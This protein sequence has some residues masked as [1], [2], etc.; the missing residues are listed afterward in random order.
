MQVGCDHCYACAPEQAWE[1]RQEHRVLARLVDESHFS[2][3]VLACAHCDQRFVSVFAEEIDWANG[4]DPQR[5]LMVPITAEE[6]ASLVAAGKTVG[7][8]AI[9]QL[10][11][12]RRYLDAEFPKG[13]PRRIGWLEGG[14]F[15]PP[16]D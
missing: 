12:G 1:H 2:I 15:I 5:W 16:H 7:E 13:A 6:A 9:E 14:F 4:D 11:A 3:T 10:A 8:S